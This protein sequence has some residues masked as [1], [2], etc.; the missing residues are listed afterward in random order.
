[1]LYW[2][3]QYFYWICLVAFVYLVGIY[4]WSTLVLLK[5]LW[6][7]QLN[8]NKFMDFAF[9]TQNSMGKSIYFHEEEYEGNKQ[10]M[11]DL[12][13]YWIELIIQKV[14]HSYLKLIQQYK[15]DKIT[16]VIFVQGW[17]MKSWTT[18]NH[19]LMSQILYLL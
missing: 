2:L 18:L 4:M 10:M 13:A 15:S 6:V 8:G 14:L 3:D 9:L 11:H 1:M 19:I 12:I 5:Q 17:K 7:L 16:Q